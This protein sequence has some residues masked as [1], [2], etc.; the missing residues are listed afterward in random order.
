MNLP[1]FTA[2]SSLGRS[3]GVYRRRN[4]S[5]TSPGQRSQAVSPA[6]KRARSCQ[7]KYG[8]GVSH[9]FPVKVCESIFPDV[10][11]SV[12]TMAAV[13]PLNSLTAFVPRSAASFQLSD[14]LGRFQRCRMVYLPF[15]GEVTTTQ[16]CDD[17][18]PDSS[19]LEV[20]GHPELTTFW[21][22]G[23]S[24]I[25]PPYN[26]GWFGLVGT[27]CSCC[28]GKVECPD[29]SCIPPNQSCTQH[30]A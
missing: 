16:N 11:S 19:V 1:G 30:P 13:G 26:P 22:G 23:L 25:P 24:Q 2:E 5:G 15:V 12:A 10:A 21:T 17:S 9:Y 28:G 6:L 20:Q 4:T 7:T 27:T 3:Q 8:G 14:R 29:G 18:M